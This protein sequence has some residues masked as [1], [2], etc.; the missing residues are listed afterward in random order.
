M[1]VSPESIKMTYQ[2]GILTDQ[3]ITLNSSGGVL[4][5]SATTDET[6]LTLS[7][8]SGSTPDNLTVSLN[9][10]VN[11]FEDGT[12]SGVVK[13]S[14]PG[15]LEDLYRIPV[16]LTVDRQKLIVSQ[17]SDMI[18]ENGIL[19][20]QTISVTSNSNITWEA[21]TNETWLTLSTSSG[22]TP[23][24]LTVSL[25]QGVNDLSDGLYP[26][27]VTISAI[28]TNVVDSPVTVN[29][30]LYVNRQQLIVSPNTLNMFHQQNGQL[31]TK[32]LLIQSSGGVLDWS[33]VTNN[34]G[35]LTLSTSSGSTSATVPISLNQLSDSLPEGTH[36]AT[37]TVIA[38]NAINSQ[39][40]VDVILDVVI[41]GTV[42][43]NSNIDAASFSISG[44]ESY[45][46]SG[47]NWRSDEIKPGTYSIQ[48]DHVQGY[49]R[50]AQ[51]TFDVNTG[52]SVTIDA[53]Y[54]PLPVANVIVAAKG[55]E[56]SNDSVIKLL[57]MNG[58]T[59]NQF[60][61]LSTNYGARVAMG[62]IDGD[63]IYEIIVAPGSG[64]KNEALFK[65]FR[66]D[67][68]LITALQPLV[69]TG[70]G[71]DVAA[72]DIDGDGRAEIAMSVLSSNN[73]AHD[74]IIY[75][76][77]P[78][79]GVN[80]I[81]SISFQ[82]SRSAATVADVAFGDID[83]DGRDELIVSSGGERDG[84]TV[85]VYDF[86]ESF[87]A[88]PLVSDIHPHGSTVCAM[89]L[90]GDGVDEVLIG[91]SDDD[92]LVMYL[93]GDL[94]DYGVSPLK[95]FKEDDMYNSG[96][97]PNLSAMDIDGDAIPDLVVGLGAHAKNSSIIKIFDDYGIT[98]FQAFTNTGGVNVA[99][100]FIE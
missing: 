84:N 59:V 91:Y 63:G 29:F 18:Y 56:K 64:S 30:D 42:I 38:P 81:A 67:G 95:V 62:D 45:I 5:W 35:W 53:A 87:N 54:R 100:G 25:N 77:N 83:G 23:D 20:S 99:L 55:P 88:M 85:T 78:S 21:T 47:I 27:G 73:R 8:S 12:Y 52:E 65:V 86:D 4:D 26:A 80:Q 71:A 93:S 37:V 50:P 60:L 1:L 94:T 48:F 40:N 6:W 10:A 46:G 15:A 7:T 96:M 32:V 17:G 75:S 28:E 24:N 19:T 33:A 82:S 98:Q 90:Y 70:Y 9:Q 57:D 16:V 34:V 51:K 49:R 41:A 58:N 97:A 69:D 66:D 72:G 61:A 14:A 11:D 13:I 68:T 92:S 89:D 79:N 43:V 31:D 76:V 39:M 36:N 3:T 74:V 44:N 2:D 22:S